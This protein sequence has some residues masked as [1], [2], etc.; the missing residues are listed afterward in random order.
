MRAAW[1][2]AYHVHERVLGAVAAASPNAIWVGDQAQHVYGANQF[3]RPAAPKSYFNS[4]TG[5]GTLGFG[6]PAAIGA[7]LAAPDRPVVSLM[8]DGGLQFTLPELATAVEHE[9]PILVLLWNN[10]GYGE[11]KKY[12]IER[13]I[14]TIGVDIRTPDFLKIAESRQGDRA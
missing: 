3:L 13:Q 11:I 7:K 12:M 14:A 2:A 5:Y 6:L 10:Y 9:T 8:G 1:P 4:S